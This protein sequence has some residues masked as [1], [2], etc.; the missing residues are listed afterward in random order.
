MKKSTLAK[1]LTLGF[2]GSF[3][4]L[5]LLSG[6]ILYW[7]LVRQL[8]TERSLLL[9]DRIGAIETLLKSPAYGYAELKNRIE[10]EWPV[11]GGEKVF[12]QIMD[13]QSKVIFE[14]P[15]SHLPKD[16]SQFLVQSETFENAIGLQNPVHIRVMVGGDE[17]Q[18]LLAVLREIL[19]AVF[20]FNVILSLFVG[21]Q[22]VKRELSLLQKIV[23]KVAKIDASNLHER[24]ETTDLPVE[25]NL[26][27]DAFNRSLDRLSDSF[28]R[29]SQF[30]SDIAHEL[31]TPA[32]NIK[33]S[34]EV[35]L[36]RPRTENEYVNLLESN[37]EE[38]ERL[39]QITDSLLFLARAEN[40]R[41]S[42][43]LELQ[44]ESL[45]VKNEIHSM[46]EFY[47]PLA[48]EKSIKMTLQGEDENLN[49]QAQPALFQR[50][51][52]NLISNA[53]RFTPEGG[54]IE[55]SCAQEKEQIHLCVADSGPGIPFS[56]LSRIF[57]RF[58]RLD[59][60]RNIHSGGTGLGLAIAKSI[61]DLHGGKITAESEL[62]S[63]SRFH[64]YLPLKSQVS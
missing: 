20:G 11:R 46:M 22:V 3:V 63:G 19:L 23:I 52:S 29:L 37:L 53:I 38:C 25:L 24:I 30:S 18:E 13:G 59:P 55:I 44:F 54:K 49:L 12:I 1:R 15:M 26:L 58:Y 32:A 28:V 31:R 50:I 61:V 48:T 33:G 41:D 35:I 42:P 64:V 39:T 5:T 56:E 4:L 36:S 9:Q 27:A 47:E 40:L 2:G 21:W 62:G 6:V 17:S 43:R 10:K 8:K 14:S 7:M 51:L 45:N 16:L 60:S 57:E 34:I